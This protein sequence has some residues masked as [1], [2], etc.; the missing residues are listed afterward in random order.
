M[1]C[2]GFLCE[3]HSRIFPGVSRTRRGSRGR[4]TYRARKREKS[5]CVEG[6]SRAS[7]GNGREKTGTRGVEGKK[8]ERE[9]GGGEQSSEVGPI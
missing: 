8:R 3:L 1:D 9:G 4:A 2:G 5:I 6:R 7:G